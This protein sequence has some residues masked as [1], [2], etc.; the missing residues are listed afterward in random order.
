MTEF[1]RGFREVWRCVLLLWTVFWLGALASVP[2]AH[3]QSR[4]VTTCGTLPAPYAAGSNM[5]P[6]VDTNGIACEAASAPAAGGAA[7]YPPGAVPITATATFSTSGASATLPAAAGKFTYITGF[8]ITAGATAGTAVPA[9]VTGVVSGN[10]NFVQSVTP[11]ANGAGV[12]TVNFIPPI[13]SS[14]VNTEIA[15]NASA[16]GAG[17]VGA[18]AVW[19]FQL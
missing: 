12:L 3:A 11:V 2:G 4:V 19:G 18:I 1:S 14:A 5:P 10:L 8:S 9:T 7:A 17:G 16:A 13:P 6:T 15:V